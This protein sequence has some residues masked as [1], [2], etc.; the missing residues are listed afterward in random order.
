MP[1]L[2]VNVL[3]VAGGVAGKSYVVKLVAN[4]KEYKTGKTKKDGSIGDTLVLEG[5]VETF[6][7]ALLMK[8]KQVGTATV[9]VAN[10]AEG[11]AVKE[12]H[13]V[14]GGLKIHLAT[15]CVGFGA[16]KS[17]SAKKKTG[18]SPTASDSADIPI[19][20]ERL[21][22]LYAQ[23]VSEMGVG[24]EVQAQMMALPDKEKYVLLSQKKLV[25]RERDTTASLDQKPQYWLQKLKAEPTVDTLK[26][27]QI[28]LSHE[29]VSWLTEF[30][31]IGGIAE[32]VNVL[33]QQNVTKKKSESEALISKGIIQCLTSFMD[34]QAGLN[35]VN[36]TP[37]A[38]MTIA[39]TYG[40]KSLD[41]DS[42]AQ[43]IKLLSVVTLVDGGHENVLAAL[44]EL[45]E[46]TG[47]KSRFSSIVSSIKKTR[48]MK[49]RVVLMTFLNAI[50]NRPDELITR[51]NLRAE[52]SAVGF[53]DVILE[54]HKVEDSVE[55][56]NQVQVY[57][58]EKEL[59]EKEQKAKFDHVPDIK[60]EDP[61]NVFHGLQTIA[62]THRLDDYFLEVLQN[63]LAI[64][65]DTNTE[66]GH[67]QW[68]LATKL[69]RYIC[70]MKMRKDASKSDI[71]RILT[72]LLQAV[73]AEATDHFQVSEL[74]EANTKTQ[75][76]LA[77]KAIEV[78]EKQDQIKKLED[79]LTQAVAKM[80]EAKAEAAKSAETAS[81]A[82]VAAAEP[83][84]A[85]AADPALT[86]ELETKNRALQSD[87]D[88]LQGEVTALKAEVEKAKAE[89]AAAAAAGA[90]AGAGAPAIVG[91]GPPP[92]PPPGMEGGGPPPPPPIGGGPPPPPPPGGA[93]GP[94]PPPPP[95][96]GGPPGPPP[97]PGM[98]GPPG[99][100]PPPGMGGPPGPPPPPG[101]GGPPPP[102][103]M[104][105]PPPPP[106]MGGPPPPMGGKMAAAAPKKRPEIVPTQKV[107]NFQWTKLPEAKVRG[108]FFAE[109][110][111]ELTSFKLDYTAV[112]G[113]FAQVEVKKA[114]GT[115]AA[116]PKKKEGPVT[117]LDPKTS[118][119]LSIFLNGF[120]ALKFSQVAKAIQNL[121]DSVVS[122]QQI[123]TLGTVWPTA[124]DIAQVTEYAANGGDVSKLALAEQFVL[125]VNA[126][127]ALL[128]RMKAFRFK[129]EYETKK[130]EIKPDIQSVHTA[131]KQ[132]RAS[133]KLRALLEIVLHIGNFLNQGGNKGQ[134]WGYKLRD[135]QKLAEA[136]TTDNKS[137]L[138]T[139]LVELV[140]KEKPELLTA[141]AELDALEAAQRVNLQQLQSELA[142]LT[143]ELEVV[144][145]SA[146]TVPSAGDDDQYH[147]KVNEFTAVMTEEV[148]KMNSDLTEMQAA[149]EA[150]V[151]YFVE[152]PKTMG[153]DE[154]FALFTAF[155]KALDDTIKKLEAARIAAEKAEK[156]GAA[157]ASGAA[158]KV[159]LPGLAG[160]K[161]GMVPPGQGAVV[162]ELFG[163]LAAGNP[164]KNRR[165][166]GE[167]AE[168]TSPRPAEGTSPRAA[169]APADAPPAES[170]R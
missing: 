170:P 35:L 28:R 23:F 43:A 90:A 94:P 145:N 12:W 107:R 128:Q 121:D 154:F 98:G 160:G 144:K 18:A 129:S 166:A 133:D 164:F 141:S 3:A 62:K 72:S 27:L 100:P 88:K 10:H 112:E 63:L 150:V 158:K 105:G 108:T 13:E 32:L 57:T 30:H 132:T 92:P 131:C 20:I 14:G 25:E 81:K 136:K 16:K 96:M 115:G 167:E 45:M 41:Y 68:V 155:L 36:D 86:A 21:H 147:G 93:G 111:L 135:L 15:T 156:R 69:L 40:D 95:G 50:C 109:L 130:S 9:S 148:T 53:D 37:K 114:E 1:S 26:K 99:P 7:A 67:E 134:S 64:R 74:K 31:A 152:D 124:E 55:L 4:G 65:L 70:G 103:G 97:P 168:G 19:P 120:K 151:T 24:P 79:E 85:V 5:S 38:L 142:K 139:V 163:Q 2:Q 11:D 46:K 104:G 34:N 17:S 116:E 149:Y 138:L 82:P 117:V 52:L 61:E 47:D 125:E 110:P 59:D 146:T 101:M 73:S 153:P 159:G 8:E 126:V 122:G 102:P 6:Q 106:G 60:I 75:R 83:P 113:C 42:R 84:A 77:T 87:V 161:K 169:D 71:E 22:H 140:Q 91:G 157:K 118:Q 137:T 143:K 48:D 127:P 29:L 165:R 54:L 56:D 119:N 58:D 49:L 33:N 123:T 76:E 89:A 78:Q 162:N 39:A 51:V 66:R 44:N 80:E